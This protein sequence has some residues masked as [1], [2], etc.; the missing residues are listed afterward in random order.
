[1][2]A[3]HILSQDIDNLVHNNYSDAAFTTGT[4]V[5]AANPRAAK[6]GRALCRKNARFVR[7]SA[8]CSQ[9]DKL[10]QNLK[11][12]VFDYGKRLTNKFLAS[13]GLVRSM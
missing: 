1:M 5:D 13:S 3:S 12:G 2:Q 10:G 6:L 4:S 9:G 11:T 8:F 7:A